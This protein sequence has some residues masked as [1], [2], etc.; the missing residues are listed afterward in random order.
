MPK[1]KF[2]QSLKTHKMLIEIF[3]VF[4]RINSHKI[5]EVSFCVSS[6]SF[7]VLI[8]SDSIWGVVR[9]V[10]LD[11]EYEYL[12]E[13][14]LHNYR[15]GIIIDAGAHVGLFSIMA[16][17]FA[18]EVIAIEPHP[19]NFMLL[20]ANMR[21]NNIRNVVTL[22]RALW[23]IRGQYELFEGNS[24]DKN[25]LLPNG[26]NAYTYKVSTVTLSDL[27]KKYGEIDLLKMDIEGAE[28][29][30]IMHAKNE[31]LKCINAIVGELHFKYGNVKRILN[32]LKKAGFSVRYF[33]LP[34]W[35]RRAKFEYKIK[36]YSLMWIKALRDL[37]K[38]ASSI[39]RYRYK[40]LAIFFA[41]R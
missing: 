24:S 38:L 14:E 9:G 12:P 17:L 35:E 34:L 31:E 37:A 40:D 23:P 21:R 32:R 39:I 5:V 26:C 33:Y 41:L 15:N 1:L 10:L 20:K 28:F 6:K 25:T 13:F 18:K 29:P 4:N 7:K 8:P 36:L 16:S 3:N 27:I 22:N 30:V 2:S 11:R 19:I